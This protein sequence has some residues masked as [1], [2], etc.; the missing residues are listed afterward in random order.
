MHN[1]KIP[2]RE[3][4]LGCGHARDKRLAL[5]GQ[6]LEWHELTTVDCYPGCDPHIQVDLDAR[7]WDQLPSDYWDEVHAYEVLEHLGQQG[8]A[9]SFFCTFGEI[10]RILKP[11]GYL[12]ATCP[13][14]TSPWLWG[15]PSHRR[16]I[17]Q[18]S[19]VFL[20]RRQIHVNRQRHS[21]LSDLSRFWRGDFKV[22]AS[23]DDGAHHTFCLQA[24]KPIREFNP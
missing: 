20:D 21:P 13:S 6:P 14:R 17:Q 16:V 9:F 18:E 1:E 11:D 15:D 5:P 7:S 8:D 12:F 3:L 4:L 10:W 22:F 2:Y 19:L 23:S 24:I